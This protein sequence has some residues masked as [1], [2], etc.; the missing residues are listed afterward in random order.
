MKTPIAA[1]ISILVISSVANAGSITLR[2]FNGS[3]VAQITPLRD[4]LACHKM[5][6]QKRLDKRSYYCIETG[7]NWDYKLERKLGWR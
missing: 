6:R 5:A 7:E 2:Y 1:F 4:E 3:N